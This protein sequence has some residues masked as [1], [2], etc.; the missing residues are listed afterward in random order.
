MK[1][2]SLLLRN[3]IFLVLLAV[4][5]VPVVQNNLNLADV[6]PLQ[7]A[8]IKTPDTSF[9]FRSWFR[10][11]FQSQKEKYLNEEFGLRNI[12]YRA[13]NQLE[14]N[15]FNKANAKGVVI[16]KDNYL[17]EERYINAACA[18][19]TIGLDSISLRMRKFKYLQ[20]T[21]AKLNKTLILVF[22]AG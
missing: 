3:I 20:D 6:N 12:F 1:S 16:G 15:L 18:L 4:L 5:I 7:G 13:N 22:A 11:D 2:S 10:G 8:I 9:S 14:F 19:D 17:Y 21:L